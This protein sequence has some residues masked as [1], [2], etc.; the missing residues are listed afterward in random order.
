MFYASLANEQRALV[1]GAASLYTTFMFDAVVLDGAGGLVGAGLGRVTRIIK[2]TDNAIFIF[3]GTESIPDI[4][5]QKG[6]KAKGEN[7]NLPDHVFNNPD[8]SGFISTSKSKDVA[9]TFDDYVYEIRYKNDGLDVNEILGD[10][11]KHAHELEM[12]IFDKI[13]A[14]DIRGAYPVNADG[15]LGDFIPNPNFKET[16]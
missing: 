12:S 2:Q 14:S 5:F 10:Q 15:S 1:A 7:Y 6:F 11:H 13:D 4:K 9:A 8:D 16:P 3:R